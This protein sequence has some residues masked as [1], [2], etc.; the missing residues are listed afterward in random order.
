M[1]VILEPDDYDLW[2][3]EDVTTAFKLIKEFPSTSMKI[4]KIGS[5]SDD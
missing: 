5:N 1:P 4:S 3:E 2:L